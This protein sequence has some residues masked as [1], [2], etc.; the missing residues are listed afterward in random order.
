MRRLKLLL[1]P[2]AELLTR[3]ELLLQTRLHV[4]WH[5]VFRLDTHATSR[6]DVVVVPL[7]SFVLGSPLETNIS[8]TSSRSS[9]TSPATSGASQ[10]SGLVLHPTP[11]SG[12]PGQRVSA[13]LQKRACEMVAHLILGP[14][15]QQKEVSKDLH[16]FLN[17]LKHPVITL[18]SFPKVA[19]II[20]PA[21]REA[22]RHDGSNVDGSLLLV[23]WNK[24]LSFVVSSLEIARKKEQQA[25]ELLALLLNTLKQIVEFEFLPPAVTLAFLESTV[26]K[27]PRTV[28][29]SPAYQLANMDLMQGTP[30]LFL[31]QNLFNKRLVVNSFSDEQFFSVVEVLIS[32]VFEGPSSPLSF[33]EALLSL[34]TC[35]ILS[36]TSPK[37]VARLWRMI[38]E[39]LTEKVRQTN[40]VSQ[41]DALDHNFGAMTRALI[42]PVQ[43]LFV[44]GRLSQDLQ[45]ASIIDWTKLYQ[46]FARSAV[47]VVTAEANV[48]CE[49]LCARFLPLFT[50]EALTHSFVLEAAV[51]LIGVMLEE[52][53]FTAHHK[54]PRTEDTSPIQWTRLKKGPLGHLTS[55]VCLL[56]RVVVEFCSTGNAP[57][58]SC[59]AFVASGLLSALSQL[60]CSLDIPSAISSLLKLLAGPIA[61]LYQMKGCDGRKADLTQPNNKLDQLWSDISSCLKDCYKGP[62]DATLLD[63]LEPLLCQVFGGKSHDLQCNNAKFWNDTFGKMP[64]W[65]CSVQFKAVLDSMKENAVLIPPDLDK[66]PNAGMARHGKVNSGSTWLPKNPQQ[67]FMIEEEQSQDF[68]FIPP[69]PQQQK[70]VLTEHQQEMLATKRVDIPVMYNNLDLS[71]DSSQFR[72]MVQDQIRDG[73][74]SGSQD[75]LKIENAQP[76]P[77]D[78][79]LDLEVVVHPEVAPRSQDLIQKSFDGPAEMPFNDCAEMSALSKDTEDASS[80]LV[81]KIP[82]E[83]LQAHKND[84]SSDSLDAVVG[85]PPKT[86][87]V[88]LRTSMRLR[89][90]SHDKICHTSSGGRG[91]PCIA[92]AMEEV[93]ESVTVPEGNA[94]RT[95]RKSKKNSAATC[96]V[97]STSPGSQRCESERCLNSAATATGELPAE[98]GTSLNRATENDTFEG[99]HCQVERSTSLSALANMPDA[100]DADGNGKTT[101]TQHGVSE[102]EHSPVS[103]LMSY[104]K[105]VFVTKR[106]KG[107]RRRLLSSD[108]MYL[109]P[110]ALDSPKLQEE[111]QKRSGKELIECA[112]S[113]SSFSK[114][115]GVGKQD[116]MKTPLSFQIVQD[117]SQ[118][119]SFSPAVPDST[120]TST[121]QKEIHQSSTSEPAFE[122]E[123]AEGG[124][125]SCAPKMQNDENDVNSQKQKRKAKNTSSLNSSKTIDNV[126]LQNSFKDKTETETQQSS[127]DN[128]EPSPPKKRKVKSEPPPQ[129]FV[130]VGNAKKRSLE[131]SCDRDIPLNKMV[132]DE[133]SSQEDC[134][135]EEDQ[136]PQQNRTK[137][138]KTMSSFRSGACNKS[139]ITKTAKKKLSQTCLPSPISYEI[140][141]QAGDGDLEKDKV[142]VQ[143]SEVES[144]KENAKKM[145][146]RRSSRNRKITKVEDEKEV[147]KMAATTRTITRRSGEDGS[148]EESPNDI[149]IGNDCFVEETQEFHSGHVHIISKPLENVAG[150]S[151]EKNESA[152]GLLLEKNES[153]AG[154]LL[155]KNESTAGL[156]LEK[157]KSAAGLLLEN[158]ESAAGLL[159]EKNGSSA[160]LLLEKKR[161]AAD[162]FL[163]ENESAAG[164]L[165]ENESAAGSLLE[166]QS[167]AVSLLENQSA[168]GSLLENQSAARSLL[169]NES[170]AGLLLENVSAASSLLENESAARS[171]LEN[172][173]AADLLLEN[174]SPAGSL[175][176][177][178]SAAGLLL[179]NESAVGSLLE[180][181]STAGLVLE[182]KSAAGLLLESKSA[183]GSLLEN[184]SAAGSL[185][186]N[187][188][189]A[190]SLLENESAAG[191]LLENRSTAGSLLEN[192]STAGSLLENESVAGSLLENESAAGSLLENE[193]AAGSLL[194]N[195]SP[196]G[197][198]LENESAAGSLLEN[199]SAAGLLLESKSA[200][201]LLLESKSAAGSL[202]E[203][204]SAAGSLLENES[205]A[206]SLLE[207][208]SAAGSLLENESAAGSLLENE[209]AAGSLLENESAAGS[210]LENESAAGSLLE[211]ESAAGSPLEYKSAAGS[212]LENE[213]AAGSPLEYESATGSLLEN[214][215][216][217]CSLLENESTDGSLLEK[218]ESAAGS[219][220]E[221]NKNSVLAGSLAE[222]ESA[223]CLILE[224]NE[225][226]AG[227]ILEGNE[228][229]AGLI[230]E[231]NESR[232][233][234]IL[235]KNKNLA[236]SILEKNVLL[237]GSLSE[238]NGR[239]AV[240]GLENNEQEGVVTSVFQGG[241]QKCTADMAL[242][243]KENA[244]NSFT[245]SS[246]LVEKQ[247]CSASSVSIMVHSNADFK[248]LLET[249][250]TCDSVITVATASSKSYEADNGIENDQNVAVE[251]T[252]VE[253]NFQESTKVNDSSPQRNTTMALGQDTLQQQACLQPLASPS[254]S[255]LKRRSFG[256]GEPFV[257]SPTSKM[258]RVSFADPIQHE[259]IADCANRRSP[260]SGKLSRSG[261]SPLSRSPGTSRKKLQEQL[262]ALKGAEGSPSITHVFPPLVG[263]KAPVEDVL[264]QLASPAGLRGLGKLLHAKN[265]LTIGDL[266]VLGVRELQALP[267]RAPKLHTLCGVLTS[268]QQQRKGWDAMECYPQNGPHED[269]GNLEAMPVNGGEV[270]TA[271]AETVPGNAFRELRAK[272]ESLENDSEVG[273]ILYELLEEEELRDGRSLPRESLQ[274]AQQNLACLAQTLLNGLQKVNQA[275]SLLF[276]TLYLQEQ[277][278]NESE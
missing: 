85:T 233:R 2:L 93:Q 130:N 230:L 120:A 152:A 27:L 156:L 197:S 260:M 13:V 166:N 251:N 41:G 173:S 4:W 47:L 187:E 126:I 56:K 167:A 231:G 155:E 38:I 107:N 176:E 269:Q 201:G 253:E 236:G 55:L 104:P 209:S 124:I 92:T 123:F 245:E 198:L 145:P 113:D 207:N 273:S 117:G 22:L 276:S 3:N 263:C 137:L 44:T 241:E 168:A 148:R 193:S 33:V 225:S 218:M 142:V 88:L 262:L 175:L 164:S 39:P 42:F 179:E 222:N 252:L 136:Q 200:A 58:K 76:C 103:Q 95:T 127:I 90:N 249:S 18:S 237:A 125:V 171:P 15:I 61:A 48:W 174:E 192:E 29:A 154:L 50:S 31:A 12:S 89:Q 226:P 157:N 144:K 267:I 40:E 66:P 194:E 119:K 139:N 46:A 261:R 26:Y 195:E 9:V 151:V 49:E 153:A 83:D 87:P 256:E 150:L 69:A 67:K 244:P 183:A 146:R 129:I 81:G 108:L 59:E 43:H 82:D 94:K 96:S 138:R 214:E 73:W 20:L 74:Q 185:L 19:H 63:V 122:Q 10:I 265:V 188:S 134:R 78:I 16:L 64:T 246:T 240:S 7:L 180:N 158:K 28:L 72:E 68:V 14:E 147:G 182:S 91:L 141:N 11:S 36:N 121:P 189:A 272:L 223:A 37:D 105:S 70:R 172:E 170:A 116:E 77:L 110:V 34:A 228:S 239:S 102:G 181:K 143:G 112:F 258:R 270:R 271:D 35:D 79:D 221:E 100:A 52:F 53:D 132:N 98:Y 191:L 1:Q 84:S 135:A 219:L 163:E 213:S 65:T 131:Q 204:E 99:T 23:V 160:S 275:Q 101:N 75:F 5:L 202:L 243:D 133:S 254:G 205:A 118:N 250:N 196:A 184:E 86:P 162:S 140:V 264:P 255:I 177:N 169:E 242:I 57:P 21:W 54:K 206:G 106:K 199:K 45:N 217:D 211:N 30:A 17:P 238:E 232:A 210:L 234:S 235:E 149:K 186:E 203:N 62:Y 161:N 165:L 227:L 109:G 257:A 60:F 114:T 80:A 208:E 115:Q 229:P 190:G 111:V 259:E 268:F 71:Q 51:R 220:L 277:K 216:T 25:S 178:E 215:S 8:R 274:R 97:Q 248:V 24:F 128:E 247:R 6:F 212:P 278:D 32:C 159:L 224:G 266:S